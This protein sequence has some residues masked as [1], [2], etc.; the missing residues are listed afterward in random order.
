MRHRD[1]SQAV[2]AGALGVHL[3]APAAAPVVDVY[4]CEYR[5]CCYKTTI[6]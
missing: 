4:K 2:L 5:A 3:G 6:D 1:L